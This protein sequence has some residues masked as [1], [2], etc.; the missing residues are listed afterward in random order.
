M[1]SRR[2]GTWP[3]WES[4]GRASRVE[5]SP[6]TAIDAAP[7]ALTAA[8]FATG[9][10]VMSPLPPWSVP[11]P[12]LAVACAAASTD[13]SDRLGSWSASVSQNWASVVPSF[14]SCVRALKVAC[15]RMRLWP[16]QSAQRPSTARER[17][18]QRGVG[19]RRGERAGRTRCARVGVLLEL[20]QRDPRAADGR[21]AAR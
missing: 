7:F 16:V 1:Q 5:S 3:A 14:M 9:R 8:D 10:I 2:K 11:P 4:Q 17:T 19:G 12:M 18:R 13:L 6:H 21:D 20:V 15:E